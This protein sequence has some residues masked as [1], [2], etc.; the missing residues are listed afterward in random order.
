[1]QIKRETTMESQINN[2]TRQSL[3]DERQA[4]TITQAHQASAAALQRSGL[5][6]D[7]KAAPG[8]SSGDAYMQNLKERAVRREAQEGATAAGARQQTSMYVHQ[9]VP[10]DPGALDTA[11]P[12]LDGGSGLG[13]RARLAVV[14]EVVV[15][16]LAPVVDNTPCSPALRR[17][18]CPALHFLK[19]LRSP[20]ANFDL[21]EAAPRR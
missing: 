14:F 16:I 8:V 20:L 4:K 11:S 7:V 5:F 10:A 12:G 21:V 9:R 3:Q 1:M 18:C 19:V 17:C 13:R 2:L 15:V 6:T